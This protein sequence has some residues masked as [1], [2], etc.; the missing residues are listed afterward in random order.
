MIAFKA[1]KAEGKAFAIA[2]L[3]PLVQEIFAISRFNLVFS[4]SDSVQEA[5]RTHAPEA[6][7]LF[8]VN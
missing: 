7:V 1:A 5:I 2:A 3:Q 8:T 6:I 4:V